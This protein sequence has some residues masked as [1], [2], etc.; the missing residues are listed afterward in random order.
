MRAAARSAIE[1]HWRSTASCRS[2]TAGQTTRRTSGRSARTATPAGGFASQPCS[3]ASI[4]SDSTG[5][6]T[7]QGHSEYGHRQP[8]HH[9]GHDEHFRLPLGTLHTRSAS[10]DLRGP[11][12][13]PPPCDR[14]TRRRHRT[15]ACLSRRKRQVNRDRAGS[16]REARSCCLDVWPQRRERR[17]RPHARC[18]AMRAPL[19]ISVGPRRTTPSSTRRS[20]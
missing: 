13:N 20:A 18:S 4:Q 19:P 17:E 10:P 7:T 12:S 15:Q 16:A 6:G 14:P 8:Q 9:A 2:P 5:S 3:I 11:G 1:P